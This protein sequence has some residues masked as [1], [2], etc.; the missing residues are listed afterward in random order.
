MRNT[1]LQ[2][3][4]ALSGYRP[5]QL[6]WVFRGGRWA[7]GGRVVPLRSRR[8]N[9]TVLSLP[10]LQ[11]AGSARAQ[12]A[13]T[14]GDRISRDGRECLAVPRWR[15]RYESKYLIDVRSR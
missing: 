2:V 3:P 13:G 8:R 14:V 1:Y 9:C 12:P 6:W 7:Y 4:Q 5:Q 10:M 15:S 11:R